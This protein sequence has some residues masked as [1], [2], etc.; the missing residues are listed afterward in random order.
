MERL[1]RPDRLDTDPNSSTAAKEWT[2]WF[3]TFENFLA[4][5][6]SEDPT[7]LNKLGILTNYVSPTV[8]E[9]ISDCT[10]YEE[11]VTLLK[12]LYIKPNNEIFARHL[13]ATRCQKPGESLD[14]Y[15]QALKTLSKDCNFKSVTAA[16]HRE[17][18]IR[19]AF[20]SGL[21]S[22]LIRQ[23]LL[24][25]KTLDL[26]TM[27]DQAR[28][29]DIAQRSSEQYSFPPSLP[30]SAATS[31]NII[32]ENSTSAVLPDT[33]NHITAA[34]SGKCPFCG[35]SM[36]P[37]SRCPARDAICHSCNKKGHFARV[38]RS[39]TSKTSTAAGASRPS[40]ASI[41]TAAA[42]P[43]LSKATCDV[44][45]NDI[46]T[47]CLVDSGSDESFIHP[48]IVKRHGI[49][50]HHCKSAVNMASASL[51]ANSLGYCEVKVTLQD[52]TYEHVRLSILPDLCADLILGR[53][54]QQLH[55]S[56][57]FK[58]GGS[59]P[60]LV[61]CG[62]T[63]LRVD[64][65]S[66]FENLTA[67]CQPIAARSRRYCPAD[68]KFIEME[69]Q[70]LLK[71]GVI[72]PSTS[73]WR[74][75]V[76]VTKDENHKK[77]LAIDYSET[78]NRFTQLDAYPL[79]RIDDTV[80]KIAQY[81]VFSTIDLR[82]AY[83]QVPIR[84]EDKP[85]TAFESSGSLYQFT[86]IPFGV[87]NG[88]ACFQ[89]IMDSFISEEKLAGTFA[90]LDNVTI[91][92]MT[93]QEHDTNLRRFLEA[94]KVKQIE[95]NEDKCVFST[96]KLHI[97]GYV[98]E[99][100]QMK[101]DPERLRPLRELPVPVDLKS[102]RRV[103]GLFSYY[104]RWIYDYSNK[105]RPLSTATTF[106]MSEE[107]EAAFQRLKDDIENSVVSAVDEE[108]SFEVETDASDFAIAATLNQAG[109]PVAF[110]SRT[111]QGAEVRHAAVEKEAQAIVETVRHWRHYLT[112]KRFTLKT[113]QR[114]VSYMF[115]KKQKSKIKNDKIM[116]WRMEL[117]CYDFDIIYRP[118]SENIPPDTFSRSY[119]SAI[120]GSPDYRILSDLHGSLCHPGVKRMYHFVR[121]R[122]LP[123]SMDDVRRIT[124]SCKVCAECKPRF[125]K[126]EQAHLI[127]AT[128]PFERLNIDFKGPLPSTDRNQ[129]FL[130]V[131]DEYSRFPFVFPCTDMTSATVIS[132]LCQ[133]F[134]IFGMPA[135]IHSDRGSSFMS[136]ELR[137]FLISKGVACSRTC[138]YNP[139]CNGQAERYNG[140]VWKAITL[141]LKHRKLPPKCWQMVL[142][143]AL[144]SI[145]SLLSTATNATPHE[146]LMNFSRR[147]AAGSS[148]PSW[149]CTPGP[150]LLRRH[151]R[152]NKTDPLVDEVEL[153]QA[154]P[155][156]AH[157]R[158]PDG[159]ETTVSLRHLAPA[160][161][162][163]E[164]ED[165]GLIP[166]AGTETHT[167][168]SV[169][170]TELLLDLGNQ[171]RSPALEPEASLPYETSVN[172]SAEVPLRR[173][174]RSRRP[175]DRLGV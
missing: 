132:C 31:E 122:N 39:S 157:V 29:L 41:T 48:D 156:Y 84:Q 117:S 150:V 38:C 83:H 20:I 90:Y 22:S 73:S 115:D 140:I 56:V 67:D 59:R 26:T 91:C 136:K 50:L 154:N 105:I 172:E 168:A 88:V 7:Q 123:Y 75:Q 143:D 58:Y 175:P 99:N 93:Q 81:R 76:V 161:V 51:K 112:G 12:N 173:S 74:A 54:F 42:P 18:S 46:K 60:P 146:R 43:A 134:A 113:D 13:L 121:A 130:T 170:D 10:T 8:Y 33:M 160:G 57:T 159:R 153:L 169:S 167:D 98:V 116:R 72:E 166:E 87:T 135:Y 110:F 149:L 107:A 1:L 144:H 100:G 14:E 127:K 61:L 62:M 35:F 119:C 49:K 6:P 89:R 138:S 64:P 120:G 16:Q 118:G 103:I 94:A 69:T 15:L 171:D 30:I 158:Y 77:R 65:P 25:N 21:Q 129:Y 145:R 44:Y 104:S 52:Q 47:D 162:T 40:L 141:A 97:L 108:I 165:P 147:S 109:R 124:A 126:P 95:Y 5:I 71:E 34:A 55:E 28:A 151:V 3:K 114:S 102:L 4:V 82:S 19:D 137:D 163:N 45:I 96:T 11:A 78:I 111:L 139:R 133:L 23:R 63:T 80:N 66:L 2:H 125:V 37:R 164:C 53:D 17:E 86:R 106:P 155:Q 142:P 131:I 101:P 32:E 24:E 152:H 92:G 128:Q 148:I 79:P 70:R 174:D 9:V 36:H 27:F 68:R 85:Y